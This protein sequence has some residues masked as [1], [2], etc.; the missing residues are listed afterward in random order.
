MGWASIQSDHAAHGVATY[1]LAESKT[2]AITNWQRVGARASGELVIKFPDMLAAGFNAGTRN[3]LTVIDADSTDE[4]LVKEM[5]VRFG[6]SP[7]H[8][9]TP[10]GGRHLYYRHSGEARR[11][12]PL[13]LGSVDILGAGNV[14]AAGSQVP[15]GRYRIIRGSLD[16]LDRL[17]HMRADSAAPTRATVPVGKRNGAL[18]R[19]CQSVVPYCDSLNQLLDAARTWADGQLAAPLPDVEIIKTCNSVWRFGGGGKLFMQHV[20]EGPLYPKLIADLEVWAVACYL[21]VE[22]GPAAQFMIADGLAE[23][24]GWPRRIVPKARKA[25]LEMG[26][27]RRVRAR[28][29]NAPALYQWTPPAI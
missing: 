26:L 14:V 22:N 1:P 3:K 10:S 20:I 13:G 25:I 19:Y 27:V 23:A 29:K 2:P 8:V 18:F 16:D 5:E 6:P 9:E 15:K 11:I 24:R 4:R 28:G 17:P 7:L 12:R 21:M